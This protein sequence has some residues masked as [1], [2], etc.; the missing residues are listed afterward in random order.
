MRLL[1]EGYRRSIGNYALLVNWLQFAIPP[2]RDG[3][4]VTVIGL[5]LASLLAGA[6]A[7]G[8]RL[9]LFTLGILW[10]LATHIR[11]SNAVP[12]QPR[13]ER[14]NYFATF[15]HLGIAALVDDNRTVLASTAMAR[16]I[17]L[18][19]IE[20]STARADTRPEDGDHDGGTH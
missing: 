11:T 20:E 13:F 4:L 3:K 16:A 15:A 18:G 17:E 14:R 7:S 9:P 19:L 12:F 1:A 8:T 5:L 10:F 2:S 6:I